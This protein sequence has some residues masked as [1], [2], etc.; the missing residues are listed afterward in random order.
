MTFGKEF[1]LKDNVIP[2]E[3]LDEFSQLSIDLLEKILKDYV[4]TM[5]YEKKCLKKGK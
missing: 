2:N 1:I 4:K 3:P 5:D